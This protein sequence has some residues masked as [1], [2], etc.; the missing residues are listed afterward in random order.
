VWG[1]WAYQLGRLLFKTGKLKKAN[2]WPLRGSE[3]DPRVPKRMS[4]QRLDEVLLEGPKGRR[5][6]QHG[7]DTLVREHC[8][9]PAR[10]HEPRGHSVRGT[11]RCRV[12]AHSRE[13]LGRC[14]TGQVLSRHAVCSP[15]AQGFGV[16]VGSH[17][18][19]RAHEQGL[20]QHCEKVELARARAVQR[21]GSAVTAAVREHPRRRGVL[22]VSAPTERIPW[23]REQ[24]LE[25]Q[26][27]IRKDG[28]E[29]V[30]KRSAVPLA[31][32]SGV[33]SGNGERQ[34]GYS[35]VQQ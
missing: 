30:V 24:R 10:F 9:V 3:K 29:E 26:Q 27:L 32:T 28:V 33:L 4:S 31:V 5:S 19:R 11:E 7:L 6:A 14:G 21:R 8:H 16:P 18:A 15:G 17:A 25:A 35:E 20:V 22:R 13:K 34:R 12:R 2:R 1:V 23:D